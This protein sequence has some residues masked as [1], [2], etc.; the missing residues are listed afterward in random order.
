M[1]TCF[2][3][4]EEAIVVVEFIESSVKIEYC[5]KHLLSLAKRLNELRTESPAT[6]DE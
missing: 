4:D 5:V 6:S 1:R 3:C 2:F